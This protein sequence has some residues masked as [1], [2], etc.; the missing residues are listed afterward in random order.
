MKPGDWVVVCSDGLTKHVTNEEIA[1]ELSVVK[2]SRESCRRLLG[3]LQLLDEFL[4]ATFRA[5]AAGFV[6]RFLKH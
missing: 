4:W 2:S 1:A 5:I 3:C 6:Q